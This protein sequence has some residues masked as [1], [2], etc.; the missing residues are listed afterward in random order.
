MARPSYVVAVPQICNYADAFGQSF[1]TPV[2][3]GFRAAESS[4]G[5]DRRRKPVGFVDP[6]AYTLYY[7]S[8]RRAMGITRAEDPSG[9]L[10]NQYSGC[11]G[12]VRFNSENHWDETFLESDMLDETLSAAALTAA[13]IK[14]KRASV[15]LG[16]AFAERNA[17]ARL[18]G[19]T[20]TRMAKAFN[21]LKRGQVRAAM[22]DLGIANSRHEP[23]GSNV[24][25]KWL[26]LQYGWKP[27]VS[28]VYGACEA[29]SKL[30]VGDWRVT[31]K[32]QKNSNLV[33]TKKLVGDP[34]SASTC[35][36]QVLRG[37]FARIDAIPD[38]D[39]IMSLSSLG[40]TNPLLIAWEL[41][42]YSFVVD[43]AFP[44]GTWLDSLDAMLGYTSATHSVSLFGRATWVDKG[45]TYT[46]PGTGWKV[47]NNFEGTK[48]VVRLI[49]TPGGYPLSVFPGI[50]DPRSLGHMANGLSLLASA[51]GRR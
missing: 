49:R 8:W 1:S 50:K 20:A 11:V 3:D 15:N 2:L 17:T 33:V 38:N 42:P 14:L 44:V 21:N 35:T 37:A 31:A 7:R 26:E 4:S 45:I 48:K 43:W 34:W 12:G 10:W 5:T 22:R 18:L 24:P 6:T 27:L 30:P 25:N 40:I 29:L 19:D 9:F 41:V 16:V 13:K 23:R 46:D 51:F 28:D 32:A 47:K 36:V 39:L